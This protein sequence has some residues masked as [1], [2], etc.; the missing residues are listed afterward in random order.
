M[1]QQFIVELPVLIQDSAVQR[2]L[3]IVH[4]EITVLRRVDDLAAAVVVA[5]RHMHAMRLMRTVDQP[6]VTVVFPRCGGYQSDL[7]G[8]VGMGIAPVHPFFEPLHLDLR[9]LE[10]ADPAVL[11]I[12]LQGFHAGFHIPGNAGPDRAKENSD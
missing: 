9:A 7:I 3:R 10:T 12:D 4:I 11:D 6:A 1:K 2:D 8:Q 5:Q